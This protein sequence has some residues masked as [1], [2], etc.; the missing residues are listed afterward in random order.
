MNEENNEFKNSDSNE[1]LNE[2]NIK[3]LDEGINEL[4]SEEQNKENNDEQN[5]EYNEE[6]YQ[7]NNNNEFNNEDN[8]VIE[9]E[10]NDKEIIEKQ[11]ELITQLK[12]DLEKNKKANEEEKLNFDVFFKENT[13]LKNSILKYEEQLLQKNNKINELNSLIT[14]LNFKLDSLQNENEKYQNENKN[15]NY[16]IIELNQKLNS[17]ND[18]SELNEKINSLN[19]NNKSIENLYKLELNKLQNLLNESEISNTKI[20]FENKFLKNKL[21]SLNEENDNEISII[22]NL[23]QKEVSNYLKSINSLTSQ[24]NDYIQINQNNLL[25][26]TNTNKDFGINKEEFLAQI[27][28]YEKKIRKYDDENFYLKK[29]IK[30]LQDENE[31]NQIIINNKEQYLEKLKEDF[32]NS[33]NLYINNLKQ[34]ESKNVE[35]EKNINEANKIIIELNQKLNNVSIEK[36]ELER[37]YEDIKNK[38][39]LT[40]IEYLNKLKLFEENI[41]I[42]DE[43]LKEYKKKISLL[44]TKINELHQNIKYL[45]NIINKNNYNSTQSNFNNMNLSNEFQLENNINNPFLSNFNS[46]TIPN[47]SN[48]NTNENVLDLPENQ[49]HKLFLEDYKE[50]LNKIDDQNK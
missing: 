10:N 44:K 11:N 8:G 14:K 23:H 31:E 2:K 1:N 43:K 19:E 50:T 46:N 18:L 38:T 25:N 49:E 37:Y 39:E 47:I 32:Q 6:N 21:D 27:S 3:F 29:E 33:Y 28:E 22:N 13:E 24:L 41:N 15:L 35:N 40:Q 26:N 34:E 17:F 45:Q 48:N 5:D 4:L 42:R 12:I 9:E 7:N 36:N 16:K 30:K 20:L